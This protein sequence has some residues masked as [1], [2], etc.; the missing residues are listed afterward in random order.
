[1]VLSRHLKSFDFYRKVPND[2]TV[3]TLP[4]A[5][6]SIIAVVCITILFLSE[7]IG[8]LSV[9][10]TS[11]LFVDVP[12]G[13][14]KLRINMDIELPKMSCSLLSVDAQDAMVIYL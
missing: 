2:L 14:E 8:F 3:A 1:M 10:T 6:I 4:G 5:T 11:Q 12:R 13:T 9:H 7:L